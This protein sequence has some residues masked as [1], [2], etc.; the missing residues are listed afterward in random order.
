MFTFADDQTDNNKKVSSSANKISMS[1]KR[2]LR[3]NISVYVATSL[4]TIK[5]LVLC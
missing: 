3:N 4:Y 1:E 2:I 5:N